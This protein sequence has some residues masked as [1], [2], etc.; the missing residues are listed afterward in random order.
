MTFKEVSN[1]NEST[2]TGTVV[3]ESNQQPEANKYFVPITVNIEMTLSGDVPV[4][5]DNARQ[6]LARVKTSIENGTLDTDIKLQE[7]M[8]VSARGQHLQ[9]KWNY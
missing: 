2:P 7:T 3:M 8:F 9:A 4:V 1:A 6:A 5:A